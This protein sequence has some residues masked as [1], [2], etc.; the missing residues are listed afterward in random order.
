MFQTKMSNLLASN[1]YYEIVNLLIFIFLVSKYVHKLFER[2]QECSMYTM[3]YHKKG[4]AS[5]LEHFKCSNKQMIKVKVLLA[6]ILISGQLF[7]WP[8]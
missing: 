6:E 8:P 1:V 4:F 5:Q 3:V 7:L 2:V